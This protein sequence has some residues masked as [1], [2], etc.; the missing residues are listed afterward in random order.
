MFR[1]IAFLALLPAMA[2][3]A[4]PAELSRLQKALS[5]DALMAILS[6]EGAVQ[7]AELRDAMFP[8]RGGIG[9][10]AT[11][12]RIYAT[13]RLKGLF[14]DAFDDAM[15]DVDAAPLLAFY[16]GNTG[17]LIARLEVE[18]RRAIMSDEVEAAARSAF[19]ALDPASPRAMLLDEFAEVNNLVDR[20][21]TGALNAN[22]AFYRG[23]NAGPGF[24]M[25]ESEILQEV[26]EQEPEI[27]QDTTG[28][29]FGYMALAFETLSDDQL[30]A[31]VDMAQSDAG[32]ALNRA[33]FA[34][35]DA[36]FGDVSYEMGQAAARFSVGDDI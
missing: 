16:E 26:W 32:K 10:T 36:V 21:V 23:L 29:I 17:A 12:G 5:T 18:A 24:D 4:T 3:A 31:Y 33:L 6:E 13:D 20:N 15:A 19:E 28:W 34:G 22:L 8:G 1:L 25:T 30:Q 35:F 14:S 9:W 11:T 2:F 7:A 27:R